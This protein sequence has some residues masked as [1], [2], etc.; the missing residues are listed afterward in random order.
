M[1]LFV[2]LETFWLHSQHKTNAFH[3]ILIYRRNASVNP[4]STESH[5]RSSWSFGRLSARL[6]HSRSLLEESVASLACAGR[7]TWKAWRAD[8]P[9][10]ALPKTQSRIFEVP[11][12]LV[13]G[14]RA[15]PP[16]PG[17]DDARPPC[18]YRGLRFP[19][20]APRRSPSPSEPR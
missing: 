8:L 2:V 9:L 12:S 11:G 18:L 20:S 13:P 14:V 17:S 16:V 1:P 15:E 19:S 7:K 5:D 3:E 10:I 6:W 4:P